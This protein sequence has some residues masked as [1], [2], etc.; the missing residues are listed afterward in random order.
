VID[1][2]YFHSIYY[3]EPGGV[4]FEIATDPPG[5]A[6]DEAKEHLGERLMLPAQY[7]PQRATLERILPR[8]TMPALRSK[9]V[10]L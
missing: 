1:R 4:L 3:R 5:F 9:A 2:N 7:E 10:R 8:L 6:I